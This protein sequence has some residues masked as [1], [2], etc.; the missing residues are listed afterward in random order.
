MDAENVRMCG[1]LL[2]HAVRKIEHDAVNEVER[3]GTR[4]L[5]ELRRKV[6]TRQQRHDDAVCLAVALV[7]ALRDFVVEL[8]TLDVEPGNARGRLRCRMSVGSGRHRVCR[9]TSGE[10]HRDERP[11]GSPDGFPSVRF[12]RE[13]WNHIELQQSKSAAILSYIGIW[14]LRPCLS[15]ACECCTTWH[16]RRQM[17]HL[18]TSPPQDRTRTIRII[19]K[20]GS[21]PTS[22]SIMDLDCLNDAL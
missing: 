21:M 15:S 7:R 9:H 8:V 11:F 14:K 3:P 20:M 17:C 2:E 5:L 13:N 10:Q 18:A 1:E 19:K 12:V 4:V 6:L 16:C 22:C